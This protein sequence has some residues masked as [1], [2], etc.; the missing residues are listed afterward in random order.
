M[1]NKRVR[2]LISAPK[3]TRIFNRELTR[4]K[5]MLCGLCLS[6]DMRDFPFCFGCC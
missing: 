1:T 4:L 6:Q 3:V 2:Q 5:I